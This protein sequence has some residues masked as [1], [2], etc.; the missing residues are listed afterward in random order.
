MR[1]STR[2]TRDRGDGDVKTPRLSDDD[3]YRALGS[4][5]RRRVLYIL[6]VEE[7]STVGKLATI[8]AGWETTEAGG[9]ASLADREQIHLALEHVHLPLLEGSGLIVHDRENDTVRLEPL[10][11]A[12][13]D[14]I[15]QS[16]ETERPSDP[17]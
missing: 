14:L 6:L 17:C 5:R 8:L 13:I 16:V 11:D 2:D 12:V 10:D 1:D 9:M 15:C 4:T 7:E 3:L